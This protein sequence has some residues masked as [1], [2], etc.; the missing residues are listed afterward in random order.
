M[1]TYL[2]HNKWHSCQIGDIPTSIAMTIDTIIITVTVK[3]IDMRDIDDVAWMIDGTTI[4]H[5]MIGAIGRL[6]GQ[7]PNR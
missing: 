3:T 4:G 6:I 7:N 5:S 1:I 2:D